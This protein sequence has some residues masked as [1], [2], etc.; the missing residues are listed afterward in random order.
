[1]TGLDESHLAD[2][3]VMRMVRRRW[4]SGVAVIATMDA[5]GMSGAT[6]SAFTVLSL[7]PPLI[8]VCL[9]DGARITEAVGRS[10]RFGVSMLDSAHELLA[11]R[12]AGRGPAVDARFTGVAYELSARGTPML[13]GALG[14]IDCDVRDVHQGGDHVLIVATVVGVLLGPDTDDPLLAYEGQFR[15]M[16]SS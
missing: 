9:Y 10:Q 4:A 1:M 14:F 6:V 5:A 15:R 3:T 11:D 2:A 13:G 7:D 8:L 12:F 16:A